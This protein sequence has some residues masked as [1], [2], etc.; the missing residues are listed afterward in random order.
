VPDHDPA[1]GAC[2]Q[3]AA[4]IEPLVAGRGARPHDD[5][6]GARLE[7]PAR[8]DLYLVAELERSASDTPPGHVHLRPRAAF[9]DRN[10][11]E[12]LPAGDVNARHRLDDSELVQ[13]HR[14]GDLARG[15]AADQQHAVRSRRLRE[16]GTEA[17][18]HGEQSQQHRD[19][20]ANTHHD[21]QAGTG[22]RGQIGQIE[23][24]DGG[25]LAPH[26]SALL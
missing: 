24:G 20:T 22:S 11:H 17:R 12:D 15:V 6:V 25:D 21:D 8:H 2:R 10:R 19:H 1:G 16:R 14:A 18:R 3:P 13:V 9:L 7:I 5:L 23:P 26:V 4:H